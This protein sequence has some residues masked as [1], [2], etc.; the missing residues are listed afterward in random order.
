MEIG[1]IIYCAIVAANLYCALT[2]KGWVSTVN[3]IAFG[4]GM[5]VVMSGNLS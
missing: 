5:A 1:A 3:W 4:F 2:F